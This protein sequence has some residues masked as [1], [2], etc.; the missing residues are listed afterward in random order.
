MTVRTRHLK[1]D[2]FGG[3]TA[4]LVAL[5]LALAFGVASGLGALAGLYGAIALGIVAALTGG[6]AIQISGPTAL[7]TVASAAVVASW[8]D[9]SGSTPALPAIVAAF[10]L[11]GL[12]QVLLGISRI[13][14]YI[15]HIPY[16]VVSAFMTG[17]GVILVVWQV[18]PLFGLRPASWK[19][20]EIVADLAR[21]PDAIHFPAACLGAV[22]IALVY[23]LPR[24]LKNTPGTLVALTTVS[25]AAWLLGVDAPRVGEL[26]HILPALV[27]PSFSL[28]ELQILSIAALELALLGSIES[29][30]SSRVA[31]NITGRGHD[32]NRELIGQGLG[33]AF[34][35]LL[36]GLPG[37][38]STIRTVV[39]ARN[40]GKTSASGVI[41]GLLLLALLPAAGLLVPEIPLAVLAGIL[42]TVGVGIMDLRGLR[43]LPKTPRVDATVMILVLTLTV[44]GELFVAIV[45]GVALAAF[46]MMKRLSDVTS[47][48]SSVQGLLEA[49]GWKDE[50]GIPA[51]ALEKVYIMHFEGPL[52]FGFASGFPELARKL[53][54]VRIVI[55]RLDRIT[56]I[57]QTAVYALEEAV[58]DF[59]SK[60]IEVLIVGLRAHHRERLASILGRPDQ[61]P[62]S[63]DFAD[64]EDCKSWLYH[65]LIDEHTTRIRPAAGGA[66]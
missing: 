58:A 25:A 36:G 41:H 32:S 28:A 11:A 27:L 17:I 59:R 57:D 9:A 24:F 19:P 44:L 37:A 22:T 53:P 33:N 31:D 8:L 2:F 43:Q 51:V 55:L 20:L 23:L 21:I 45:A 15:R 26:P 52:F 48:Q 7:M 65:R 13:G 63:H 3:L 47:H 35:G 46:S 42:I 18:F 4:A 61:V 50:I 60:D 49:G 6:T 64:F 1:D 14:T 56:Y 16:P 30:Q 66:S 10:V 29:L 34:A 38:G 12:F 54:D 39:N 5:P 62:A 40:G